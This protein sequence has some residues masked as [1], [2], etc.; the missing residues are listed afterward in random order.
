MTW[1]PPGRSCDSQHGF[2]R[3][4]NSNVG[5]FQQLVQLGALLFVLLSLL[6]G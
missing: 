6:E 5:G 2:S 1:L 3:L 4:R